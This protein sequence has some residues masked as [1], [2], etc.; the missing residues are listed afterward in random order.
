M[1]QGDFPKPTSIGGKVLQ[2][3]AD[4]HGATTQQVALRFLIDF[5]KTFVVPKA[6]KIQHVEANAA[7]CY[8]KLSPQEI[9]EIDQAF[10]K[11]KNKPLPVI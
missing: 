6:S 3:I 2:K 1:G 9:D 7:A 8:L 11:G 5:K 4:A 10:P